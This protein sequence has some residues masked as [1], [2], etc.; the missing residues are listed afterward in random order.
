MKHREIVSETI[1]EY[2]RRG[3]YVRIYPSKN[4]FKYDQYFQGT[5][6]LNKALYKLLYTDKSLIPVGLSAVELENGKF[7]NT[8]QYTSGLTSP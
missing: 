8:M 5:R 6:P 1:A 3:N 4:C 7:S 2:S